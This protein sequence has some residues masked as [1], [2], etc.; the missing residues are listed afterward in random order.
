MSERRGK[1]TAEA[2]RLTCDVV[3]QTQYN[4]HVGATSFSLPPAAGGI[5]LLSYSAAAS[6]RRARLSLRLSPSR[7]VIFLLKLEY[8]YVLQFTLS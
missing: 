2:S 4:K 6:S 1:H 7:Y 5:K 8:K 3:E